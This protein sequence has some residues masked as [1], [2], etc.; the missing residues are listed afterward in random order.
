MAIELNELPREIRDRIDIR[1]DTDPNF[2]RFEEDY[3][4]DFFNILHERSDKG[5]E[6]SMIV[7]VIGQQGSGKSWAS[8]TL[9]TM[10]DPSFS[11]DKIFFSYNDLVH[12]RATLMPNTSVL[13][14]EQSQ[15]YGLDSNRV[16]IILQSIKEQLRKKSIH[17]FFCSPVLHPEYQSSM[18]ILETMFIDRETEEAVCVLMTR[19]KHVLGH[20]R[21]PSPL[22]ILQDG[23]SV[24]TKEFIDAYEAK[25]DEH[26]EKILG[27]KHVDVFEERAEAVM[28]SK[29]FKL[30]ER[31]YVKKLGYIPRDRVV[32]VIN[33]LF[34]EY[35]AGVVPNEIAERIRMNRELEGK[36][37]IPG[38]KKSRK[39]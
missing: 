7:S 37:L 21:V 5:I 22:K 34:P 30:A 35:N 36:W 32:Q 10:L 26:L 2:W 27:Q 33:K 11:I 16:M 29:L 20:V 31:V 14:D 23:R 9:C 6:H 15:S 3:T 8:I 12:K 25:K 18:Y 38:S 13:L 1:N 17:M 4:A 39:K 19:E 24:Q 28:R